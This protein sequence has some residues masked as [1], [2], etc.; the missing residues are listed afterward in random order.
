[1]LGCVD[2]I[3][4]AEVPVFPVGTKARLASTLISPRITQVAAAVGSCELNQVEVVLEKP[5]RAVGRVLTTVNA[6]LSCLTRTYLYWASSP[7]PGRLFTS[8]V[9]KDRS[10][11]CCVSVVPAWKRLCRVR[12]SSRCSFRYFSTHSGDLFRTS[13]RSPSLSESQKKT[14]RSRILSIPSLTSRDVGRATHK[15][16]VGL[17]DQR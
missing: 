17:S 4:N 13:P 3:S 9:M 5:V 16:S 11:N 6:P 10:S 12:M 2:F 15:G 14:V 8:L 1:M 7:M